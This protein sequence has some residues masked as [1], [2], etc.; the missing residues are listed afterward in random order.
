LPGEL[1]KLD[2]MHRY[3]TYLTNDTVK[4]SV[5]SRSGHVL[6]GPKNV[7]SSVTYNIFTSTIK[8]EGA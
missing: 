2:K 6:V 4:Y 5:S 7:I 1:D 8:K 3:P